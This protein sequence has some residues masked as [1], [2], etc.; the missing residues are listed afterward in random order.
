MSL[1]SAAQRPIRASLRAGGCT[2]PEDPAQSC[3]S[4]LPLWSAAADPRVLTA[5]ARPYRGSATEAGRRVFDLR[6]L[7]AQVAVGADREHARIDQAGIMVR[8]DIIAGT[9][10]NGPVSLTFELLDGPG[11]PFQ[12]DALRQLQEQA[13]GTRAA[14]S[15]QRRLAAMLLPL[16]AFDERA[17]GAS[18]RN[19]AD[20]LLGH[21]EWPGDGDHRK[22]Q[23]RRLVAAGE[24]LVRG[25]SRA[26]LW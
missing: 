13:T 26:I 7:S 15:P 8:L 18:L 25:G 6:A 11:L 20:M 14:P 4:I 22:S 1:P 24:A 9:L 12:I 16:C 21:G 5:R 17:R 2:F 23:A 3:A 19:I 10:M